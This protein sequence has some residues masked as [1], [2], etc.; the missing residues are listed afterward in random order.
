MELSRLAVVLGKYLVSARFTRVVFPVSSLWT[1]RR[2]T[3]GCSW[4][5][6]CSLLDVSGRLD[7]ITSRSYVPRKLLPFI[8]KI[9][10][11]NWVFCARCDACNVHNIKTSLHRNPNSSCSP[12]SSFCRTSNKRS[13]GF[14]R[15]LMLKWILVWSK[16]S[17]FASGTVFRAETFSVSFWF[18]RGLMLNLQ[19]D[20]AISMNVESAWRANYTGKGVLVA[21]VDDGVNVKHPDL[22]SNF[23]S[24]LLIMTAS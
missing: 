21:V 6:R 20:T 3:A 19:K 15:D 16:Q 22:V 1:H 11:I 7:S 12:Q 23:V 9:G 24:I 5:L 4:D 10:K 13:S 18:L 8:S 17:S 2:L 14:H